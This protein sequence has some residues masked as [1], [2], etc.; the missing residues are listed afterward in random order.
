MTKDEN[1]WPNL[2]LEGTTTPR[3]IIIDQAQNLSNTTKNVLKGDIERINS[4]TE[5]Q[6]EFKFNIIAPV[7]NDY[8]YHLFTLRYSL[9]KMYPTT[10][11]FNGLTIPCEDE[12]S[13]KK[14]LKEIFNSSLTITILKSLYSQSVD[15]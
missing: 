15:E 10:I 11:R 7:L 3:S 12:A 1:L 5:N 4:Q 8:I 13:F 6:L 9:L 14:K 2:D